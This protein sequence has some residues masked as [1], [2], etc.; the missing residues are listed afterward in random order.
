MA[1]ASLNRRVAFH[2][3]LF[4]GL[5]SF[6][7]LMVTAFATF[8]YLRERE[9]KADELNI[10]LQA[11]NTRILDNLAEGDTIISRISKPMPDLRISIIDTDGQMIFD[12]SLD[13]LPKAS[14]LDR[15]EVREAMTS[16][17]G[18]DVRR[19]SSETGLQYFYSATR[20]DGVIVRSAVPYSTSLHQLLAPD[21]TFLW[22][23]FLIAAAVCTLGY[24]ATRNLG[25]NVSRLNEF[26]RKAERGERIYDTDAFPHNELGDIS[27]HIV[28]L[29][30]RLQQALAD[31]DREH[32][33]AMKQQEDKNRIKRQLTNNINHELKTP[34]AAMGLCL[35]TLLYHPGLSEEK[36]R[37]FLR[38]CMEHNARLQNLLEDVASLTRLEDGAHSIEK[39]PLDLCRVI[40]DVCAE[41]EPAAGHAGIAIINKVKGEIPFDGN[42]QLLESVFRN[43]FSNAVKYSNG[44]RVTISAMKDREHAVITFVDDGDGIAPE[45]LVHIF[46]RFYRVDKGRSRASGGTGLGLAIVKNALLWH[47]AGIT[48]SPVRPHGLRFTIC[49]PAGPPA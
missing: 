40:E 9:F 13:S 4:A 21:F 44:T 16:G 47:G 24:F 3:V 2:R 49:F 32:K 12:N 35:E 6:A 15:E 43:L 5:L 23:T 14:H 45:H 29:Y 37:E 28:R 1:M 48:A 17:Q 42:R 7:A 25:R 30:S 39:A 46:E 18:Y 41:F 33:D 26:A 10:R 34:V 27:N 11:Y 19:H 22:I 36:R 8:Q 20:G 38:R 31:R